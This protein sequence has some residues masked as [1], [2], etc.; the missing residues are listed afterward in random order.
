VK[1]EALGAFRADAGQSLK[2]LDQ[3]RQGIRSRH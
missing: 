2:L 1:G 3:L